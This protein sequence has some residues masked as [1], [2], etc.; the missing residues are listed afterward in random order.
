M[1][2]TKIR[3]ILAVGAVSVALGL[4]GCGSTSSI[5][6]LT[7]SDSATALADG[8]AAGNSDSILT[9]TES[10]ETNS[11]E[12]IPEIEAQTVLQADDS[13]SDSEDETESIEE[14]SS[15]VSDVDS[16]EET[17]EESEAESETESAADSEDESAIS[18]AEEIDVAQTDEGGVH[19]EGNTVTC[20]ARSL[21]VRN[22]PFVDDDEDNVIGAL[23]YGDEV[24]VLQSVD[25]WYE[26]E[27]DGETG[28]V[29][30]NYFE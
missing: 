27:Y 9:G 19:G 28:W 26:I 18:E 25:G 16:D 17:E 13:G 4:A 20:V 23:E 3:A 5:S 15:E 7:D 24:R 11:S 1:K 30:S 2:F 12:E 10:A 22:E 29:S 21:N 14:E 8:T 6:S